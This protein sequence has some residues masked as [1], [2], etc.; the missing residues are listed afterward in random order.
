M[1]VPVYKSFW[2]RGIRSI[3]GIARSL[4]AWRRS[5]LREAGD[6][7]GRVE[8]GR[9]PCGDGAFETSAQLICRNFKNSKIRDKKSVKKNDS[10]FVKKFLTNLSMQVIIACVVK[11]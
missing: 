9:V 3:C 11:R 8:T 6:H 1:N 5:A 2:S 7:S 4:P 10:K